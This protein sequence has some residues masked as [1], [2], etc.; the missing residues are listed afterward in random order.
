M[1]WLIIYLIRLLSSKIGGIKMIKHIVCDMG[2][3][4]MNYD[5]TLTIEQFCIGEADKKL[6][7]KELFEGEE[8]IKGDLGIIDNEERYEAV[9]RRVPEKLHGALRNCVYHWVDQMIPYEEAR[10]FV[11]EMKQRGYKVYVLSN[12][13]TAFY[14]FFPRFMPLDFFDGIVVSADIH[15]IKPDPRIYHYFLEKYK[16]HAEECLFIDDRID[17]V[18]GARSVGMKAVVFHNDFNEVINYLDYDEK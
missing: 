9:K 10:R 17:N 13:S 8:W 15:M 6:I 7:R 16:L 1:L 14:D 11:K 4:L 18:E 5:P 2:N 3:V 12:A